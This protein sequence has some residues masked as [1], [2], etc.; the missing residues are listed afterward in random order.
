MSNGYFRDDFQPKQTATFGPETMNDVPNV[1]NLVRSKESGD[2]I[3]WVKDGIKHWVTSPEVLKALGK[4]FGQE[5]LIDKAVMSQLQSGEPIRMENVNEFILPVENMPTEA[6]PE[7]QPPVD[8]LPSSRE[9]TWE[10][11]EVKGLTS[12]I[13]P[14]VWNSYQTFHVTG[15][16]IGSIREHTDKAK[17]PYEIILVING[18]QGMMAQ[19]DYKLTYADKV[20]ENEENKG[21]AAAVNQGIRMS[22]GEYIAIINNDVTVYDHWLEDLQNALQFDLSLVMAT[23][24]YG[25]PFARAKEANELRERSIQSTESPYSEFNDFSCVLTRKSLFEQIGVFDEQFFMYCEDLDLLKRMK[26]AGLPY[27]STKRVNTH[28]IIS[29]TDIENKAEIMNESKAK[30]NEKWK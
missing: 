13:I 2:K 27:A 4:D 15:D 12:I 17:T 20:I 3:Y 11:A 22:S 9:D 6:T 7:S 16:C 24:M 1:P 10:N 14:V 21:Y 29:M 28:H 25:M 8:T 19:K 26:E 18:K 30:F 23:P 5:T